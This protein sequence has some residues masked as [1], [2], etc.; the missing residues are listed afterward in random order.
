MQSEPQPDSG[1][2]SRHHDDIDKTL[3]TALRRRA[4]DYLARREHSRL[5]LEL[6][7]NKAFPDT[8]VELR[9]SVLDQLELDN[10]L[11]DT[12]FCEAFLNS[13]VERGYGPRMIRFE[14]NQRGVREQV[15]EEVFVGADIDW[16]DV[17]FRLAS[18]RGLDLAGDN[19]S[20]LS[21]RDW[22]RHQR[23]FMSRGFSPEIINCV[24]ELLD[25]HR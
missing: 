12:R 23:Y 6:K 13:R 15:V 9:S 3:V 4:M 14:L 25:I 7:L 8:S 16:R 21:I 10:L 18:R 5:E 24:R 22:Q 2:G 20:A 17:I 1:Q 19:K 11:S